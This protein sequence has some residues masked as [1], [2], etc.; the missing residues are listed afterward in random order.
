M[1]KKNRKQR[2]VEVKKTMG[3]WGGGGFILVTC[4]VAVPKYPDEAV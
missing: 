1:E 2:R 3:R 4:L